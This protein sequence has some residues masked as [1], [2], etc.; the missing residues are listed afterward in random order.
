MGNTQYKPLAARHGRGM[1]TAWHVLI[2][3]TLTGLW[4]T[5]LRCSGYQ[6]V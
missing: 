3:L 6:A 5:E 1:R 2:S 4:L